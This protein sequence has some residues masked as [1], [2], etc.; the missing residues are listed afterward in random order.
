MHAAAAVNVPS[1]IVYGGFEAPWQSGYPMNVNL[2]SDVECA[3]CWLES[4][5]PHEKKCMEMITPEIVVEKT[6]SLLGH[7]D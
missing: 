1:V 7:L 5:C 2:Y 3:P 6:K 4:I